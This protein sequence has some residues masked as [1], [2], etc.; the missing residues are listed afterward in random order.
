MFIYGVVA[1]ERKDN[2]WKLES[3]V[4]GI[5]GI[6]RRG[7]RGIRNFV[8]LFVGYCGDSAISVVWPK[9]L[10]RVSVQGRVDELGAR[11]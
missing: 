7:K 9:L 6:V 11:V 10:L 3:A 1:K 8:V 5:G 2:R 4:C